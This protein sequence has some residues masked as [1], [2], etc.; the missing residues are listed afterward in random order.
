[1]KKAIKRGNGE[2]SLYLRKDGR[3]CAAVT[4]GTTESG[5]PRRRVFYGKTRKEVQSKLRVAR[6]ALDKGLRMDRNRMTV[7]QFLQQWLDESVAVRASAN[8]HRR[9]IQEVKN[10]F[11]PLIGHIRLAKLQPEDVQR[12]LNTRLRDGLAPQ[13]VTGLR[14]TIRAALHQ[15]ERWHL[16]SHNAAKEVDTPA[17]PTYDARVLTPEQ[18]GRL[19]DAARGDRLETLFILAVHLGMRQGELTGLSWADVDW[20]GAQLHIRKAVQTTGH[21]VMLGETK[22]KASKRTLPLT[23]NL[24]TALRAHR[25]RQREEQLQ[26]GR[27]N[28]IDLIFPSINGNPIDGSTV[29]TGFKV[30]LDRAG[31]PDMRFHDL[32]HSC[33]TFLG[34]QGVSSRVMMA[35]LGH[36]GRSMTDRYTHVQDEGKTG[37]VT[38]V[39][40]LIDHSREAS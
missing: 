37:A 13:S 23:P 24:V 35:I 15:A 40:R 36:A 31:L 34:A 3:W 18:A 14:S 25:S 28:P 5:T 30:L 20:D 39:D 8:T 33:A 27:R 1:M 10:H 16:V 9:Y 26:H 12:M 19:L 4:I 6:D 11:V 7:G 17:I 21:G 2:G 38:A 32:R 29:R 22:T